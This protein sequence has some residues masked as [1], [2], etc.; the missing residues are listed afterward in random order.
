MYLNRIYHITYKGQY[1]IK[2]NT[3]TLINRIETIQ[4]CANK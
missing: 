3:N 2:I 1:A 4:L